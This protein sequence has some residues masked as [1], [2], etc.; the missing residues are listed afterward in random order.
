MI[1][2][3]KTHLSGIGLVE[4]KRQSNGLF[5]EFWNKKLK[6]KSW[7]QQEV[8][9]FLDQQQSYTIATSSKIWNDIALYSFLKS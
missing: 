6:S 3:A 2:Y 5:S 7:T 8:K 1:N 9:E 4:F